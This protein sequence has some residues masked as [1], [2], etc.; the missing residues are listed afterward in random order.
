MYAGKHEGKGG[1]HGF[2][3]LGFIIRLTSANLRVFLALPIVPRCCCCCWLLHTW[4]GRAL[5]QGA[6]GKQSWRAAAAVAAAAREL[7]GGGA[8]AHI[9]TIRTI[10]TPV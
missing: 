3:S 1:A 7:S 2:R 4:A 10:I 8:S 6:P 5:R 9:C